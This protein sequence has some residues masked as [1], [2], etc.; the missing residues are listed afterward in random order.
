MWHFIMHKTN[1]YQYFLFTSGKAVQE[2]HH[3]TPYKDWY[4]SRTI[5]K[6]GHHNVFID[7]W[8]MF[9]LQAKQSLIHYKLAH[10]H[11]D[12]SSLF[13]VHDDDVDVSTLFNKRCPNMLWNV[14]IFHLTISFLKRGNENTCDHLLKQRK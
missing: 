13:N 8:F 4:S 12:L 11:K 10:T 5:F 7:R 6:G 14:P 2:K 1:I 9:K 3:M